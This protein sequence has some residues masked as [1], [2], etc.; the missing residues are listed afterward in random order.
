VAPNLNEIIERQTS[1]SHQKDDQHDHL[2]HIVFIVN[3]ILIMIMLYNHKIN[4]GYKHARE[5]HHYDLPAHCHPLCH[6]RG[7]LT[8]LSALPYLRGGVNPTAMFLW[9]VIVIVLNSYSVFRK[10]M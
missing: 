1:Q 2:N 4:A 6:V 9:G 8:K 10:F 3:I 5:D 7:M